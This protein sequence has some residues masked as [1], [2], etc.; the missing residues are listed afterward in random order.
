MRSA[1]LNCAGLTAFAAR[2]AVAM[3]LTIL[4][5]A[6]CISVLNANTRTSLT[7]GT[8]MH[9]TRTPLIKWFWAIY[10]VATDKRGLSALALSRKIGIGIKCA[11]TMLHKIRKAME[12]RDAEYQLA[13][14][15]QVD[16]A[17]FNGGVKKGG[18][19]R[20]RGTSKVPVL[21]MA[22]T[23]DEAI[24]FARMEV[25]ENV[26]GEHIKAI[27]A[28]RVSKAQAIKTDGLAAFNVV[29]E[30]GHEHNPVVGL[31][32]EKVSPTMMSSSGSTSWYPMQKRSFLAHTMALWA[33]IFRSTSMS[34]AT[35]SNRR[36]WPGQGFDRLLRAC[37]NATPVTYAEL[38]G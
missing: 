34:S 36:F 38:R 27:L 37:S 30:A 17:F 19:K 29:K 20:G 32:Q 3:N 14:L 23:R 24:T 15:I 31:S 10:L 11:W 22:A 33:S 4:R 12:A 6:N 9:R 5:N 1:C 13:G 25:L 8:V 28:K 26:D 35:V 2:A 21:V 16:D 18:D 7:A